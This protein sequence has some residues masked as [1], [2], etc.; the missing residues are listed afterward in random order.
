MKRQSIVE[1]LLEGLEV[2]DGLGCGLGV[3]LDHDNAA[4]GINNRVM[5]GVAHGNSI[6]FGMTC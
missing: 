1:A 2:F 4:V 3:K 6:Q 5:A